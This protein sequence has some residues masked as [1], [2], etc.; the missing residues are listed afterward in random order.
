VLKLDV[1]EMIDLVENKLSAPSYRLEGLSRALLQVARL[2]RQG[3]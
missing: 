2:G 3:L 1:N